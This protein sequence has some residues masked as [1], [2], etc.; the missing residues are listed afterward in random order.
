MACFLLL[1]AWDGLLI[2][3]YVSLMFRFS[4]LSIA[5]DWHFVSFDCM[6]LVLVFIFLFSYLFV[7]LN[8]HEVDSFIF[9]LH[10]LI[11]LILLYMHVIVQ[12][13]ILFLILFF[14]YYCMISTP[15]YYF[16]IFALGFDHLPNKTQVASLRKSPS[17]P[18]IYALPISTCIKIESTLPDFW[19]T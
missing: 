19:S 2:L 1:I 8:W 10:E 11:F 16:F 9:I 18:R 17:K 14:N 13:P 6:C 7:Y 15:P 4:L 3:N 5:L 12:F